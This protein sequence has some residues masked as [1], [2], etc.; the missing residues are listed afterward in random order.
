MAK[1]TG[2]LF[3]LK[4]SGKFGDSIIFS[5]WKGLNIARKY[6]KPGGEPSPAQRL[7]QNYF[8]EASAMY[9]HLAPAD[10]QAWNFRVGSRPM[11]GYNLF[12][13]K[14]MDAFTA[15]A[16][17][18]NLIRE[19]EVTAEE[20]GTR[21]SLTVDEPAPMLVS[22][23]LEGD[24]FSHSLNLS[25]D[26]FDEAG[27]ASFTLY[28][29]EDGM[30][31]QLR[32]VQSDIMT[33]TPEDVS[34]LAEG[35]EGGPDYEFIVA[36]LTSSDDLLLDTGRI[37]LLSPGPEDVDEENP[38]ELSWEE[39]PGL[40]EYLVYLVDREEDRLELVG[41]TEENSLTWQGDKSG[42]YR[43]LQPGWELEQPRDIIYLTG[44][45]GDYRFSPDG[46][47]LRLA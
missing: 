44:E 37:N 16:L 6:T 2:P 45:S 35:E 12:I 42:E 13:K 27:R 22:W 47:G 34:I 3:S 20:F 31:Y 21:V 14:V 4:A 25:E 18:Y 30:D 40:K 10:R 33:G 17:N 36:A 8:A 46:D 24:N 5:S 28:N 11:T 19:L 43:Q 29:L 9:G 1:V 15:G 32:L 7:I 41:R 23:G 38:I 39:N 26:D